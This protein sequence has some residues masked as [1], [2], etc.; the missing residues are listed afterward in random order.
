MRWFTA[1]EARK[2]GWRRLR[3]VAAEHGVE[4]MEGNVNVVGMVR[5]I[6]Y[7]TC[8][9]CQ[10]LG[11]FSVL[12]ARVMLPQLFPS[13]PVSSAAHELKRALKSTTPDCGE[14]SCYGWR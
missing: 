2:T 1:I 8:L 9:E 11:S 13:G 12:G 10:A 3:L 6:I 4:E 14:S 7:A 5:S